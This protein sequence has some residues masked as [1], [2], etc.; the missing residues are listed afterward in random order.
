MV[1]CKLS[2]KIRSKIAI[3]KKFVIRTPV[4][5]KR[6]NRVDFFAPLQK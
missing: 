2:K 5:T 1:I 4:S 6:T 3:T